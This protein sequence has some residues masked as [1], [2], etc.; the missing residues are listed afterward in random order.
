MKKQIHLARAGGRRGAFTLI[1]VLVALAI[2]ALAAVVLGSAY[3][4]L[5]QMHAALRERDGSGD[6]LQWAR[7]AL[8]VEPDRNTAERGG[9]V[10]LPD[11]RRANW[12]AT[13]TAT[14][15]S[16]LFTVVLEMDA[17]PPEGKGGDTLKSKCEMTLLRPTWSTAAERDALRNKAKDRI[18]QQRGAMK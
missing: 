11:G 15:V 4:N 17:P 13:I 14:G 9:D 12:R 3:I 2:F 8:L 1:E 7:A 6:D 16:D 5:L 10:I 18:Q